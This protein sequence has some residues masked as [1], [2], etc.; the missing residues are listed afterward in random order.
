MSKITITYTI[1]MDRAD[2]H[3]EQ[4]THSL[5]GIETRLEIEGNNYA[6]VQA[7]QSPLEGFIE[8]M[9]QTFVDCTEQAPGVNRDDAVLVRSVLDGLRSRFEVARTIQGEAVALQGAEEEP[10]IELV[11]LTIM[12]PKGRGVTMTL[13]D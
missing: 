12:V 8:V 7:H 13:T 4:L 11:P 5:D 2:P 6:T 9:W 10:A 3:P 1:G